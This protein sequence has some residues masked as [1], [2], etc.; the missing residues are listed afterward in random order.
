MSY[1]THAR[2]IVTSIAV[3][4]HKVSLTKLPSRGLYALLLISGLNLIPEDS[5]VNQG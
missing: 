2:N 1:G 3:E 4:L 5:F